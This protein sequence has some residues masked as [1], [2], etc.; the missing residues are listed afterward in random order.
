M[1]GSLIITRQL[2]EGR[3]GQH[4]GGGQGQPSPPPPPAV[5][6]PENVHCPPGL[7]SLAACMEEHLGI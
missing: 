3:G 1:G 2:K 4:R 7:C 5:R 6:V